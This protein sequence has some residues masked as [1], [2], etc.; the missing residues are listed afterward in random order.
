MR[1]RVVTP[2]DPGTRDG[3]LGPWQAARQSWLRSEPTCPLQHAVSA[4]LCPA[5]S[6]RACRSASQ[7]PQNSVSDAGAT[8]RHAEALTSASS[9]CVRHLGRGPVCHS[10][11][12]AGIGAPSVCVRVR[13]LVEVRLPE[14]GFSEPSLKLGVLCVPPRV[15]VR[16]RHQSHVHRH[17]VLEARAPGD[18]G[19]SER[20]VRQ[21][22]T[23]P[24]HR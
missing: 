11:H 3:T 7:A 12:E 9:L 23:Q 16:G 14:A 20:R 10:L 5:S 4:G 2:W 18:T 22:D 1:W 13:S 15:R 19:G 6:G 24:P 8:F 17:A 21:N